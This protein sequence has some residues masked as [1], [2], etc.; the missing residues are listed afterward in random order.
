MGMGLGERGSVGSGWIRFVVS[1]VVFACIFSPSLSLSLIHTSLSLSRITAA[2]VF[3]LA[4]VFGSL[5]A[6]ARI[7]VRRRLVAS[8]PEEE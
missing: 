8:R 5:V 7:A 1:S 4:R 6:P 3:P 2:A